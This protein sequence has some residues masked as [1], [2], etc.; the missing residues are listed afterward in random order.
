MNVERGLTRLSW[1]ILAVGIT[2]FLFCAWHI[3]FLYPMRGSDLVDMRL[4]ELAQ[5]GLA[6]LVGS[7]C[8]WWILRGFIGK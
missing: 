5:R 7:V 4:F 8:L 1:V 3:S 6:A 2:V